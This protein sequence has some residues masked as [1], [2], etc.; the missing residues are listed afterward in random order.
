MHSI[1]QG[2]L[3][4]IPV[5]L[6]P[7]DITQVLPAMVIETGRQLSCFVAENAK[8]ARAFLKQLPSQ[9][10]LQEISIRELNEH[11]VAAELESLLAPLLHGQDVGLI[12]EAGCPAVA[13][14]GA[15]L[16]ALAHARNIEVVPF[17]GPSSILLALMGS[18]LSGQNFAFHG[19]LPAKTEMRKVRIAELEKDSRRNSRTQ[20]FIET[21][22][23]NQQMLDSLIAS[24]AQETRLCLAVDL[25][26]DS[27]QITTRTIQKWRTQPPIAI[28]RRPTVFLLQA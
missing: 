23:R 22:Y 2:K 17:V 10:A 4:L 27:Q 16:V 25:T 14:P 20:I 8:S 28:D 26:L 6:G 18:G 1:K 9:H 12:S 5:P 21:P 7:S 15:A 19:Y 11:T 24:C 13:D 3:Y